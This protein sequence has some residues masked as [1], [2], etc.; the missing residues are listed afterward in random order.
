MP[1]IEQ[2]VH[3]ALAHTERT[4]GNEGTEIVFGVCKG[5]YVGESAA[6][7]QSL[8]LSANLAF[9]ALQEIWP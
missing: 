1:K 3:F 9:V 4:A 6:E 5:L 7:L 2:T 8:A